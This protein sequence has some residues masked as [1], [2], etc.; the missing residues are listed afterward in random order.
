MFKFKN[1]L[2]PDILK[3]FF[4]SNNAN[5]RYPT[6]TGNKLRTPYARTVAASNFITKTGVT[7]WNRLEENITSNL[8]IGTFKK[9]LKIY[10]TESY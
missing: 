8:K 1:G 10:L 6:R 5:H 3:N 7:A 2:L 9:K 4:V